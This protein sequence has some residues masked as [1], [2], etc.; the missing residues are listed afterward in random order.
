MKIHRAHGI[1]DVCAWCP[2]KSEADAWVRG[3][4]LQPSHGCC[5]SC[6]L[7]AMAEMNVRLPLRVR[8]AARAKI[9]A[10]KSWTEVAEPLLMFALG[11]LAL[12]FAFALL[13]LDEIRAAITGKARDCSVD[14]EA[15]RDDA[16]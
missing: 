2:G 4:G 10:V 11:F 15:C 16:K 9:I 5:P 14:H 1:A 3:H 6:F 7:R 12:A 8:V 13:A